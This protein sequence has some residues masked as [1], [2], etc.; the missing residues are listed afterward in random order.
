VV[1]VVVGVY[2]ALVLDGVNADAVCRPGR[3]ADGPLGRTPGRLGRAST[4]L[5][6]VVRP[7]ILPTQP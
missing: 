5:D 6:A 3:L 4:D 2:T 7:P 1:V